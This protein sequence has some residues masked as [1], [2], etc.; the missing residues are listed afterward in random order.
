M[1]K[2]SFFNLSWHQFELLTPTPLPPP[3][4]LRAEDAATLFIA[5]RNILF[6]V[7][8]DLPC[9]Q[10]WYHWIFVSLHLQFCWPDS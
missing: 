5:S 9:L 4:M 2:I 10:I 7:H 3:P 6:S 1:E 8:S